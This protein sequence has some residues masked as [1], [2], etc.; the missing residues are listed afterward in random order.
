VGDWPILSDGGKWQSSALQA[1]TNLIFV[2]ANA[3]AH[4]KGAWV[5]IISSTTSPVSALFLTFYTTNSC[6]IFVD[7]AIGVAGS[8]I[9]ILNNLVAGAA[10]GYPIRSLLLSLGIPA[11]VRIAM[12]CQSNAGGKTFNTMTYVIGQGF[13]P[14]MPYQRI[15]TYGANTA[16]TR[17]V[18]YDCGA[19]A[20][21]KAG[22]VEVISPTTNP[23]RQLLI[24][25]GNQNVNRAGYPRFAMDIGVGGAGSEIIEVANVIFAG[26]P[27]AIYPL[28]FLFNVAIPS[29][30]R[31]AINAQCSSTTAGQRAFDVILYGVD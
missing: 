17:G 21:T 1:S 23:I 9:T 15:T 8:E 14:S 10:T 20:N 19:A 18:A 11:G 3:V 26:D 5:E 13:I 6:D 16:T 22:W 25:I 4:V 30:S 7:I 27:Y 31:I 2:T 24:G 12:R 28:H 29:G